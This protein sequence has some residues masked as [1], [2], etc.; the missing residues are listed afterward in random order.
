MLSLS[1]KTALASAALLAATAA[2]A[3]LITFTSEAA[4]LAAV[5][6]TGVDNFDD[7]DI[8]PYDGPLIREAG[9]Y[10][11]TAEVGPSTPIFFGAG[12]DGS[13]WWLSSNSRQDTITFSDFTGGSI[14]GA[15]GYFFGSDIEGFSTS[16]GSITISATDSTGAT[17]TYTIDTPGVSSF[18]GFVSTAEI[19]SLSFSVG[20]QPGVWPTVNDL[21][22]SVSAVPE[23][24]TYGMML[25]GLG[26]LGFAARRK[27]HK[28]A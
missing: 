5:G 24:A 3:E 23:P 17:L 11:Y 14:A 8:E 13:D 6:T 18:V 1:V 19:T 25:A 12:D 27:A 28:A 21:H 7:L 4:Y 15:G 9:S 2:H 26:L 16:A 20:N 10:G 22:L